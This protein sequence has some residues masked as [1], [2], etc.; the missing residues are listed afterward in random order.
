ML[1]IRR[2]MEIQKH[3]NAELARQINDKLLDIQELIEQAAEDANLFRASE[4]SDLIQ[5]SSRDLKLFI[6]M[7]RAYDNCEHIRDIITDM[8]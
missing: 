8:F 1:I 3:F 6:D 2:P 7:Q 4:D 5:I